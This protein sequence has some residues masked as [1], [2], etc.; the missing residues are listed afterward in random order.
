MVLNVFKNWIKNKL[1]NLVIIIILYW[2]CKSTNINI[3][4]SDIKFKSKNFLF[5]NKSKAEKLN[6]KKVFC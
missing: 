2:K 1:S 6:F 5:V 3:S 4:K